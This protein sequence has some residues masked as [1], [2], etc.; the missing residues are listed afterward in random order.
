MTTPDQSKGD[1]SHDEVLAGEYVVGVL[2]ANARRAVEERMRRDRNFAAIVHRWEENLSGFDDDYAQQTPPAYLFSRIETKLHGTSQ[3]DVQRMGL[4]SFLWTSVAVWRSLTA[5]SLVALAVLLGDEILQIGHIP[6]PPLVAELAG[7][8]SS[9]SLVARYDDAAGRLQFTPV[10][11]GARTQHSLEV[12]LIEGDKAPLS[13]GVLPQ[14]GEGEITIPAERRRQ[15]AAGVVLAV[16][17][18]P[19]GGSPTGKATGPILALGETH[20]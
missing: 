3:G 16:S 5:A 1:R 2:D 12:W 18:E 9:I 7:K 11:T 13:L 17:L 15:F 8:D 10:A 20:F 19:F 6:R 14:T 4:G